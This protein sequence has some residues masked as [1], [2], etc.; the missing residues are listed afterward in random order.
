LLLAEVKIMSARAKALVVGPVG[1]SAQVASYLSGLLHERPTY[2]GGVY[3]FRL[4]AP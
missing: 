1:N 2:T 4:P 3:V